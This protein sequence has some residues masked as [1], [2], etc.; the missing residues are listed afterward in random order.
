MEVLLDGYARML[1]DSEQLKDVELL[2]VGQG[3][4]DY[5]SALRAK[6]QRISPLIRFTGYLDADAVRKVLSQSLVTIVPSLWLEN[7]PNAALESLAAGTPVLASDL[8]SM[9]EMLLGTRAGSL[10]TPGSASSL[11]LALES[12]LLSPKT[13]VEM[14]Q[15]ARALAETRYSPTE[16]IAKLTAILSSATGAS[17]REAQGS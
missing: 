6:A 13:W 11:H 5:G 14:S 4:S 12:L 3:E 15:A 16:H 7:S 9:R 8:G 1:K 17:T 2:I 10:F